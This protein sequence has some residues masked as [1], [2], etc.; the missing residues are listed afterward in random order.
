MESR[1]TRKKARKGQKCLTCSKPRKLFKLCEGCYR[2]CMREIAA[3]NITRERA[4]ELGLIGSKNRSNPWKE[5][6]AVKV[7]K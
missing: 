7:K 2:S 4:E 1:S 5:A 6:L 3:G